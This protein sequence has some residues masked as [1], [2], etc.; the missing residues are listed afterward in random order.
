MTAAKFRE[1]TSKTSDTVTWNYQTFNV[2]SQM[3]Y[4][5][6]RESWKWIR[7]SLLQVNMLT[8]LLADSERKLRVEVGLF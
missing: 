1:Y 5:K 7:M 4:Y 2:S 3:H 6:H 8:W